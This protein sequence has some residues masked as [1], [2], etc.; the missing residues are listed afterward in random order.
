M[1]TA[2]SSLAGSSVYAASDVVQETPL[3]L[4]V[5]KLLLALAVAS[6]GYV[7]CYLYGL[8]FGDLG[9]GVKQ[10]GG[11]CSF[12]DYFDLLSVIAPFFCMARILLAPAVWSRIAMRRPICSALADPFVLI[13]MVLFVWPFAMLFGAQF[14]GMLG[15]TSDAAATISTWPSSCPLKRP[16]HGLFQTRCGALGGSLL[17]EVIWYAGIAWWGYDRDYFGRLDVRGG[18]TGYIGSVVLFYA[19]MLYA[20]P[21]R[22]YY[23]EAVVDPDKEA[24]CQDGWIATTYIVVTVG[25]LILKVLLFVLPGMLTQAILIKHKVFG[26]YGHLATWLWWAIHIAQMVI[27]RTVM[28]K[29]QDL[30]MRPPF[31]A[32]GRDYAEFFIPRFYGLQYFMYGEFLM[33][34]FWLLGATYTSGEAVFLTRVPAL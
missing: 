29:A 8:G 24:A 11:G 33:F 1:S 14:T 5:G 9:R 25:G 15:D 4:D 19:V 2:M 34:N 17:C 16:Y 21:I 22:F 7:G 3:H 32:C 6:A 18:I 31:Q 30:V 10:S 28:S 26:P 20:G 12:M 23:R 13:W 27:L